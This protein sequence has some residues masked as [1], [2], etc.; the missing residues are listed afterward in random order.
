VRHRRRLTQEFGRDKSA[1]V[2]SSFHTHLFFIRYSLS[3]AVVPHP[4]ARAKRA[5]KADG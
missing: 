2:M 3:D 5:S 4:E 1:D